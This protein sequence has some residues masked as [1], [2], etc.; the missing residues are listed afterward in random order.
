EAAKFGDKVGQIRVADIN[1]RD[2]NGN[3]TGQP[4]GKINADD[5]QILGSAVPKL[6]AGLTNRFSYKGFDLSFFLYGRF[7]Q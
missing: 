4:D 2:A 7:G 3:L 1:G 6:V 5:R